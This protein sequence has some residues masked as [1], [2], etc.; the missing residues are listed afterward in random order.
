MVEGDGTDD[1]PVFCMEGCLMTLR[2]KRGVVEVVVVMDC[3][4]T[5][6]GCV[7]LLFIALDEWTN[8]G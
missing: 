1:G 8:E 5:V 7:E 6:E 4:D 3:S 2:R